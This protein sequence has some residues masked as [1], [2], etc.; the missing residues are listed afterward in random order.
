[1]V[2]EVASLL[3][4]GIASGIWR[5]HLPGV[6]SLHDS[7]QVGQSTVEQALHLLQKQGIIKISHGRKTRIIRH[8]DQRDTT[9]TK[10]QIVRALIWNPLQSIIS[11]T[12]VN[13]TQ[14]QRHLYD[15]GFEFQIHDDVRLREGRSLKILKAFV[16]NNPTAGWILFSV[17]M[18]TQ[19]WFMEQEIPCI[20]NGHVYQGIRLPSIDINYEAAS[21]HAAAQLIRLGQKQ[22]LCRGASATGNQ[23]TTDRIGWI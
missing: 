16:E 13:L 22:V 12:I 15:A 8:P 7:L 3:H 18:E 17:N 11:S 23:W 20:V 9:H 4:E 21:R 1:M 10:S 19:K 2:V 14:I 5:N 6:R